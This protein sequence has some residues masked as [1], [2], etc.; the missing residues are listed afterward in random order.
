MS[1][2]ST[3]VLV[4]AAACVFSVVVASLAPSVI[5][6]AGVPGFVIT[7]ALFVVLR[8][9]PAAHPLRLGCTS[10]AFNTLIYGG[11]ISLALMV[12]RFYLRKRSPGADDGSNLH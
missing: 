1:R 8:V 4:L 11:L 3:V 9:N 2:N 10:L 12:R 7:M 5:G 6:A